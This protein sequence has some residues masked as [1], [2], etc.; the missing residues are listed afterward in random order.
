MPA[1]KPSYAIIGGGI[2]GLSA[3][4][5]LQKKMPKAA[6]TVFEAGPRLGGVLKTVRHGEFLIESSAD[7]FVTKP[8]AA[9]EL[10]HDLGIEDDLLQTQPVEHRAFIG[11]GEK[12]FPVP[13]GLSMM[14][15]TKPQPILDCELLTDEGK[16][17]F[18]SEHEIEASS[19]DDDE[20]L[21]SFAVRR[22]GIEA[23]ECMP[24]CSGLSIWSSSMAA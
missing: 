19:S 12:I 3:A 22:F 5:Y 14:V 2:S 24:R 15:P 7:M 11:L 16:S 1:P 9:I 4:Y 10:C 8:A 23:Y 20:S 6:I 18:L 21:K 13:E 17:R